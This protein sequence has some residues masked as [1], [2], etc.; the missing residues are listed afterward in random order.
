[1]TSG[2]FSH[3]AHFDSKARVEAYIRSIGIP[4]TFFMPGYFMPNFD[5]VLM[6]NP[7]SEAH[8]YLLALPCP[9]DTPLPLLDTGRDTGKF[10]KAIV[11]NRSS[12]LGERVYGATAYYT[13]EQVIKDFIAAKPIA[14]KGAHFV[15]LPGEVFKGFLAKAGMPEKAQVETLEMMQFFHPYGYYGKASLEES[16]KV[17]RPALLLAGTDAPSVP[18]RQTDHLGVL[19]RDFYGVQRPEVTGLG[20]GL[21]SYENLRSTDVAAS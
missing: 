8:E 7:Q 13:P 19:S 1:M 6:P 9:A 16:Q 21:D 12:L 3:V 17:R 10:V 11:L 20:L 14:G 15:E 2:K 5:Q 18:H 4:A